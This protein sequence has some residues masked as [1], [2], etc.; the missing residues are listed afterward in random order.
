MRF[1]CEL[2]PNLFFEIDINY[3]FQEKLIF[4]HL[5]HFSQTENNKY[6]IVL[7]KEKLGWA[8]KNIRQ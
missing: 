2:I 7:I 6:F 3:N 4:Y 5:K 1:S 8:P